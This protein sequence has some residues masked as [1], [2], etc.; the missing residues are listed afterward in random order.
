MSHQWCTLS[1]FTPLILQYLAEAFDCTL[2]VRAHEADH[3]A[4]VNFVFQAD[5]TLLFALTL[6]VRYRNNGA[7]RAV[8]ADYAPWFLARLKWLDAR[9]ADGRTFLCAGRFTL[10]DVCAGYAACVGLALGLGAR[11][12]PA[13]RAYAERLVARPA[14]AVVGTRVHEAVGGATVERAAKL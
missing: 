7:L 10:A 4:F 14:W 8:A 3:A 12:T 13:V 1:F 6:I 9:L 5:A 2:L 11:F